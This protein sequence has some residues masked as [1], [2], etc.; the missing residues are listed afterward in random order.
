MCSPVSAR[1]ASNDRRAPKLWV[2]PQC[3]HSLLLLGQTQGQWCTACASDF[4]ADAL[5]KIECR[6]VF[7]VVPFLNRLL[8]CNEHDFKREVCTS[9]LPFVFSS[10]FYILSLEGEQFRCSFLTSLVFLAGTALWHGLKAAGK[11]S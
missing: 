9:T 11:T 8:S 4:Q 7:T 1:V 6:L 5:V 3:A 2:W 10:L